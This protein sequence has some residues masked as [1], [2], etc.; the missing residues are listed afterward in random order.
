[1]EQCEFD[2]VSR[3]AKYEGEGCPNEAVISLGHNGEWHLCA[4][5]AAMP[6]FHRYRV[7]TPIGSAAKTEASP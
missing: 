3:A 4:S 6:E 5:C 7:R 2:P 1:M